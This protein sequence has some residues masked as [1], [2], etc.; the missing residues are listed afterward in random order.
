[1]SPVGPK[2]VVL[3]ANLA[4]VAIRAPH[5]RRSR[6]VPVV[7]SRKGAVEMALLAVAFATFLLPFAWVFTPWIAFADYP[8]HPLA[9]GV[10]IEF[11]VVGLWLFWR[12][13]RDLGTNWSPTLEVREGHRLVTDGVYRKVRHPM[14]TSLL[15]VSVGQGLA[16]PNAVAGPAYLVAMGLMIALRLGHEER[17]MLDRFG[18]EYEAYR[19]R[20][21]RLMPGVW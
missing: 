6:S 16:L 11:L 8:A 17:M 10:G 5:G 3:V 14:Y 19:S 2:A 12:S 15:F 18:E 4:L 21:K 1:V 7:E 20:T 9:F 13:H